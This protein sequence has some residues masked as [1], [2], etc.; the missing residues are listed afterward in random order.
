MLRHQHST[1]HTQR[2]VLA[3]VGHHYVRNGAVVIYLAP[4]RLLVAV[5]ITNGNPSAVLWFAEEVTWRHVVDVF[6]VVDAPLNILSTQRLTMLGSSPHPFHPFRRKRTMPHAI[7]WSPLAVYHDSV[8]PIIHISTNAAGA[9]I[10][11]THLGSP[12]NDFSSL[13]R[14][15]IISFIIVM[16]LVVLKKIQ[17]KKPANLHGGQENTIM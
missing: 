3:S 15:S 2:P 6:L 8:P 4:D 1:S 9:A 5:I 11:H 7:P 10:S 16:Y 12:S 13:I 17:N 14:M